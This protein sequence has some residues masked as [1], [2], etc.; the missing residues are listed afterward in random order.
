MKSG[1]ISQCL[2]PSRLGKIRSVV[3]QLP[4]FLWLSILLVPKN[5]RRHSLTNILDVRTCQDGRIN[6]HLAWSP[7]PHCWSFYFGG[8]DTGA[9]KTTRGKFSTQVVSNLARP[10]LA[11]SE[12]RWIMSSNMFQPYKELCQLCCCQLEPMKLCVDHGATYNFALK[13]RKQ[14]IWTSLG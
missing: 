1:Q 10:G 9:S 2:E 6:L 8:G 5:L 12:S 3:G 11:R 7:C 4:L 14:L 13:K